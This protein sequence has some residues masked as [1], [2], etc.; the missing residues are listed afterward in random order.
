MIPIL[1]LKAQYAAIQPEIDA[2][3]KQVLESTEFVLGP[4]V[5]DLEQRIAAY[6]EC[7][8]GI[9]VASGTDALRLALT[10]LGIGPGDEVIT[11][12]FTFIATANTISHCGAKPVFV[13]IDPKTYNL[14]P[15]RIEAAITPDTK[16]ILPVHLY[17]QP[18]DM[19]P[20]LAMAKRHGLYVVE[21]S[22]QAIGACYKGRRVSSLG[23]VGCLSFYPTKNLG[24]YGDGGM[25]VTHDAVLAEKID[26][27]R[28]HGGK[29]KYHADVLGFNSRLDALQAAVLGVKLNHLESWNEQRRRVA[30]RYNELLEDLPVVTPYEAPGAFHVYH[31]YTIRAEKRDELASY[32]KRSQIGTMV[33]YPVPLH[34]QGMYA[35]LGYVEGDLPQ[36]EK[37]S[38][39]VL[40]LPMYP[41]LTEMQQAQ[42]ATA[43]REFYSQ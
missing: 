40:S 6:C 25:V 31:Q 8:H 9:G 34:Q 29:S 3:L 43:I 27:L 28:R 42:V 2:A 14:D 24:A 10:S 4:T 16:A 32:L 39:E 33:Y 7:E 23:Q 26:I 37:A 20:I 17:G 21:D 19:E 38:R 12:P 15:G 22:A 41:E 35:D 1:D 18:A 36:S 13:D 30:Q 5:R 11:T